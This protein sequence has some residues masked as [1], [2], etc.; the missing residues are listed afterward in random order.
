MIQTNLSRF[1]NPYLAS[2]TD[3]VGITAQIQRLATDDQLAALWY[4]YTEMGRA[5]A[6]AA[7][8]IAKFH[9][10]ERL[11]NQVRNASDDEQ[12]EI[13]R[14]LA[15]HRD[16]PAGRTYGV[17]KVKAKL[18]FWYQLA[19]WMTQEIVVPMPSDYSMTPEANQT[20]EALKRLALNQQTIVLRN[21]V[22]KM[23]VD[24]LA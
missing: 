5:I 11:L 20:L 23:G 4:I 24:P 16:T 17:L 7:L 8:E 14:D 22:A 2:E 18:A 10:V 13:M 19:E 15:N 1:A 12:L 9:L 6:P 21:V 3:V